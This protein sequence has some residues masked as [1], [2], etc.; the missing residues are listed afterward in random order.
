T[1]EEEDKKDDD[2][3]KS[4]DL[5]QT[6]DEETGDEFMHGEEHVQDDD[7]ETDDEFGHGDEQVN[8]EADVHPTNSSLLVS[9]GFGD[10]F[11]K[12]SYDTSLI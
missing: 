2:D 4:I 3:D 11:L 1:D 12:L 9:S 6:D 10:Q 8:D 5:E 7:E